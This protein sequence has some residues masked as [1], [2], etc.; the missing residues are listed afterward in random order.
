MRRFSSEEIQKSLAQI[1]GW[2]LKTGMIRKTFS[3]DDYAHAMLFL[4]A[5]GYLAEQ[6]N[7]HPDLIVNYKK[8]TLSLITHDAGGITKNDIDLAKK[9]EVLVQ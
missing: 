4:N 6:A 3:F 1:P 7:H 5:V 8:V 9:I 2:E